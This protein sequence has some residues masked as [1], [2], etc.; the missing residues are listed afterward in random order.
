MD[1]GI[2]GRRAIVCASS[3]GLGPR[4][5][6]RAGRRRRARHA[7]RARRRGAEED[8]R[9][10]PQSQPR[11]HRDRGGRR[12]HHARRP[13]GR[14]EGLSRSGYPDQQCRR[15]AAR[16]FPQLDPR[17]LDQGDRRQHADAD[18]AD[19]GDGGRHDGAQ[20][21]PHRQH[22]LG[23]GEGADRD[24]GP[25]QR[26][27]R[28]PD[29]LRRR[30]VAQDRDQQRHHQRLAAGPVRHRPP[31][32][33]CEGRRGEA[34]ISRGTDCWRNG[35]NSIRPDAS[36]TPRNSAWP[37]RSCAAPRPASSPARTSC[38]TAAPSRAR[39]R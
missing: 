5:R 15:P 27:A 30:H 23:R 32:R 19:Q 37:A 39:C 29:R 17:R 34:R 22:H 31:A 3:K 38:S 13:R 33:H 21:R 2:K 12:H 26:R 35:P 7:D 36:A 28:R 16:R 8:R 9:R 10:N 25:V 11:R 18:R 6:H 14:A 20:V 1:L 24:S 4:L